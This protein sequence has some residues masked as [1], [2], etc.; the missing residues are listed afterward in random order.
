[1]VSTV[2]FSMSQ[3]GGAGLKRPA[4][5]HGIV[6]S[7]CW[8]WCLSVSRDV[9]CMTGAPFIPGRLQIKEEKKPAAAAQPP[10]PLSA[11][12]GGFL[13]QLVRETE[14]ETRQ[15]EPDLKEEK[16]VSS[17]EVSSQFELLSVPEQQA[18]TSGTFQIDS[19]SN[20]AVRKQV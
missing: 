13:K 6:V 7:S 16:A 1:M 3:C 5:V 10:P 8:S 4:G 12:P 11:V 20:G 9:L 17:C 19:G 15:K 2:V 14:K 18:P